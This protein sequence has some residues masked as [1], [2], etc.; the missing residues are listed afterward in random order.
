[1]NTITIKPLKKALPLLLL[2]A[3]ALLLIR[4]AVILPEIKDEYHVDSYRLGACPSSDASRWVNGA[5]DLLDGRKCKSRALFTALLALLLSIA[6]YNLYVITAAFVFLNVSA[7]IIAF[8]LLR[9]IRDNIF[10]AAFLSFISLWRIP[11]LPNAMPENLA[12]PLLIVSFALFIKGLYSSS[13]LKISLGF[14]LLAIAQSVRAWDIIILLL[15][16]PMFILLQGLNKNAAKNSITI[17]MAGCCALSVFFCSE[18]IF[19][20]PARRDFVIAMVAYGQ[21]A[22]GKGGNYW[23]TE[24]EFKKAFVNNTPEAG[25]SKMIYKKIFANIRENPGLLLNGI[26]RGYSWMFKTLPRFFSSSEIR[27]SGYFLLFFLFYSILLFD[28]GH[29]TALLAEIRKRPDKAAIAIILGALIYFWQ[30]YAFLAFCSLGLLY[31]FFFSPKPFKIFISVYLAGTALTIILFGGSGLERY[32]LSLVILLFILASNGIYASY[33]ILAGIKPSGLPGQEKSGAV[34]YRLRYP[35]YLRIWLIWILFISFFVLLPLFIRKPFSRQKD[36]SAPVSRETLKADLDIPGEIISP[37]DIK[38]IVTMW[39]GPSFETVH[40][41]TAFWKMR[42]REFLAH[43][44]GPEQGFRLKITDYHGLWPF[45]PMPF[46]RTVCDG[47]FIIFPVGRD[48]LKIFEGV[49]IIVVG[50][51]IAKPRP[52]YGSR[53]YAILAKIIGYPDEEGKVTWTSVDRL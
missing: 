9:G 53:G 5:A 18:K 2:A 33:L 21:S 49:E 8:F 25:L 6:G 41:R 31:V 42:Y 23:I 52:T 47:D 32:A 38:N 46:L 36:I 50:N 45:V 24:P 30:S 1:M 35:D 17:A 27:R 26:R 51:I 34:F 11:L 13:L 37:D 28:N 40:G 3:G 39:P 29:K 15:I 16:P 44:F 22:G 19:S 10:T 14:F 20:G 48:K 4:A 12:I 7:V 43:E